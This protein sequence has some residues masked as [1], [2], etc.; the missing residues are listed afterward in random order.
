LLMTSRRVW[1]RRGIATA[2]VGLAGGQLWRHGR[3]YVF[4]D[5]F[6]VVEPGK[7][8]RGA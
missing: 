8:Y 1:I 3:D 5:R 2:L 4:V 7:I 6:G